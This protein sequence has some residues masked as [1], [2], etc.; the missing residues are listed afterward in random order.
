MK[1]PNCKEDMGS[2]AHGTCEKCGKS[3]GC[4]FEPTSN[5]DYCEYHLNESFPNRKVSVV[6]LP[7]GKMAEEIITTHWNKWY[8]GEYASVEKLLHG[9]SQDLQSQPSLPSSIDWEKLKKKFFEDCN[10]QLDDM[11]IFEWFKKELSGVPSLPSVEELKETLSLYDNYFKKWIDNS[12]DTTLRDV[13]IDSF[14]GLLEEYKSEKLKREQFEYANGNLEREILSLRQHNN[15]PSVEEEE[16][17]EKL[18]KDICDS[19]PKANGLRVMKNAIQEALRQH[20]GWSDDEVF[21]IVN[22]YHDIK[23]HDFLGGTKDFFRIK[24]KQWLTQYKESKGKV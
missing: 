9:I 24:F 21:D 11:Q 15:K 5:N 4:S 3:C 6:P 17:A 23:D 19:M 14:V 7:K 20:R 1:C 13:A 12:P 22:D 8:N 16:I 18:F 2:L 10:D